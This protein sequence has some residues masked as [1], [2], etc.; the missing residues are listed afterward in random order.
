VNG[1]VVEFDVVPEPTMLMLFAGGLLG[2]TL[3]RRR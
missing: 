3:T 1:Y 2:L